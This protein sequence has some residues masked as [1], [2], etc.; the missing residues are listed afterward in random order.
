MS[1]PAP[2]G[3]FRQFSSVPCRI[4]RGCCAPAP[5]TRWQTLKPTICLQA[6]GANAN[7]KWHRG[8]KVNWPSKILSALSITVIIRNTGKDYYPISAFLVCSAFVTFLFSSVIL[9]CCIVSA[10]SLASPPPCPI[11]ALTL[12]AESVCFSLV[13]TS[14]LS[15][16]GSGLVFP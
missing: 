10:C 7:R 11:A 9:S 12:C 16:F 14:L 15:S 1:V 4:S 3:I 8:Q 13:F 2:G 6:F 5:R